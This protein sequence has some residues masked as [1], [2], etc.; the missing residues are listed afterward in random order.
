MTWQHC[1]SNHKIVDVESGS[2]LVL[3]SVRSDDEVRNEDD[4]R[5]LMDRRKE[6]A[7]FEIPEVARLATRRGPSNSVPST[8][9]P[10]MA[11]ACPMGCNGVTIRIAPEHFRNEV[12]EQRESKDML[13]TR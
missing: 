3:A 8:P 11:M 10:P 7:A 13:A 1:L 2:L 12:V 4:R 6:E 5:E 9:T